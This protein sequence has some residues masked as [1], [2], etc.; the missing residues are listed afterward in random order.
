MQ[1]LIN[2]KNIPWEDA[3]PMWE[4]LSAKWAQGIP[5]GG[6]VNVYLNNPSTSSIWNTIERPILESKGVNFIFR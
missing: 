5:N 4:R 2:S 6:T 1:N 3:K